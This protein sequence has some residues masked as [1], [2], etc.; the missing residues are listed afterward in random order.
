MILLLHFLQAFDALLT[1]LDTRGTR[2]SHLH[3]MLQR[4]EACFKGSVRKNRLYLNGDKGQQED[5][6][7]NSSFAFESTESPTS[8]VSTASFDTL[9]PSLSFRIE[10]GKNEKENYNFMKRYEDLQN[11]MWKECFNSSIVRALAYGK[12]RCSQLLGI[13]DICLAT[14]AEDDCPCCRLAQSKIAAK[15]HFPVPFNC[16]NNMMDGRNSPLRIRLI[17][18]I[19]ISLEVLLCAFFCILGIMNPYAYPNYCLTGCCSLW[20]PSFFLVWR[21]KEFLGLWAPQ[22]FMHWWSST[23]VYTTNAA[24]TLCMII[25]GLLLLFTP[26]FD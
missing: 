1:A 15:G 25:S 19:L 22:L 9:E 3:I 23:G 4:I 7:Q 5:A 6:E 21:P 8:A 26:L 20:G 10:V 17:K 13:C 14:Y 12:K 16:E 18:T 24:S 11:W 2:E